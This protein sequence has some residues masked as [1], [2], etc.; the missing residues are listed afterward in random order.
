M[1]GL[2]TPE[3][4]VLLAIAFLVFGGKKLPEIG[5]GLGKA[6][7]SFKKG[8][9]EVEEA[10]DA[11]KKNIPVVKEISQVRESLDKAKDFTGFTGK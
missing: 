8:L 3:L 2:G 10:S 1:F 9:N 6:I 5:S 4:I 11:L 7:G